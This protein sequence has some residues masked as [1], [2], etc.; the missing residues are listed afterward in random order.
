LLLPDLIILWGGLTVHVHVEQMLSSRLVLRCSRVV[1]VRSVVACRPFFT[2]LSASHA[3][4]APPVGAASKKTGISNHPPPL[5]ASRSGR[6]GFKRFVEAPAVPLKPVPKL[7][8]ATFQL[9]V[10]TVCCLF[11]E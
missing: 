10:N 3:A 2:S 9:H 8:A 5:P 1:R 7:D 11:E 6:S 4:T